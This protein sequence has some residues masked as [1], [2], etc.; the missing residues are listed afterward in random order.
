MAR[1]GPADV[2]SIRKIGEL[3]RDSLSETLK[4]IAM[5]G[6]QSI[7]RPPRG[8]PNQ[9]LKSRR[10]RLIVAATA[11]SF[12]ISGFPGVSGALAEPPPGEVNFAV[13]SLFP[14]FRPAIH[15]YVVR[16]NDAPVTVD[17]HTSPSWEAAINGN[18]P[19][20]SGDFSELVPLRSG[21]AFV[22][23][24]RQVGGAQALHR[25]YARC[26][27]SSFPTYTFTRNGP[28]SPKFFTATRDRT[29]LNQQYGMI[30]D[31]NGVPIWWIHAPVHAFRVLPN[32]NLLWNDHATTPLRWAIH[33]LDGT[34]VRTLGGV[35]RLPDVHDLQ[36]LDN[37]DYLI[38]SYVRQEHVDTS[39]YGG[40]SDA[41]VINTELQQVTPGGR[42]VWN[43]KSQNHIALAET[44]RN[45][46][47]AVNHGY[48]IAHWNS[49]E[50]A[51]TAAVIASFRHF[52]AVYRIRKSTRQ[53]VWK[54]GGTQTPR[55]LDVLGDPYG[56]TF[57]NQHDAR[58]LGDGTV[59]VFDNRTNV[60]PPTPRAVRFRINPQAGTATLL[61]SISDPAASASYCCGSA[62]RLG[63]GDWL[64]SWGGGDNPVGGY[65]PNG[66]R[67]FLLDFDTRY[68][69]RAQPVPA[70]AVSAEDLRQGMRAMCSSGCD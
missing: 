10:R 62:R 56:Y 11:V 1:G 70:G 12:A 59:T 33:R 36:F 26:L 6:S 46:P 24:M 38:G 39:A 7:D 27:P 54:L 61:E 20:R 64:I 35:G 47:W 30:F 16:C 55:S 32:G 28:V 4:R 15:N 57:G 18:R 9:R 69:G 41:T 17:V 50:P 2:G 52:D 60:S 67:T 44:G 3:A 66:E 51:G 25:Y 42:L 19:F 8:R 23:L 34:R 63:N 21:K 58:L 48:D 31:N 13:P 49:I 45:W 37:G 65:R 40:S 22:V 68:S 43:W 29:P 53:I 5:L 14:G